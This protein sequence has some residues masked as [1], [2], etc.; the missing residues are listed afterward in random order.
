MGDIKF[1][2]MPEKYNRKKSDCIA[3]DIVILGTYVL[4]AYCGNFPKNLIFILSESLHMLKTY[5]LYE[6]GF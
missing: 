4:H 5:N 3:A 1:S 2:E 6:L